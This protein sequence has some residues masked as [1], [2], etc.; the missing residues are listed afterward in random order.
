MADVGQYWPGFVCVEAANTGTRMVTIPSG[1][2][3]T[4][5]QTLQL[6]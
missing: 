3:H 4:L 5:S 2:T 1:G 6:V